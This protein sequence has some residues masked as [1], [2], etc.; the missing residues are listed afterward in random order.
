ME[1]KQVAKAVSFNQDT[2]AS[3]LSVYHLHAN[4]KMFHLLLIAEMQFMNLSKDKPAMMV[5]LLMEMD[6]TAYV[7]FS[8][9]GFATCLKV[10]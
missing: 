2:S 6:A 4:P 5:I 7:K 3:I 1:T 8:L 10:H 9:V